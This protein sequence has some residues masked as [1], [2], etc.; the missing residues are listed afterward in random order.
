MKRLI[1]PILI[2]FVMSA[3]CS[4]TSG[5]SAGGQVKDL[6]P[7]PQAGLNNLDSY[8]NLLTLSFSG[9]ANGQAT[10]SVETYAQ[11]VWPALDAMFATINA[12]DETG[13]PQFIV[14]GNV[15]DA[16]YD[17]V[18]HEDPCG[19]WWGETAKAS[20]GSEFNVAALL[21]PVG[22]AK[23][24]GDETVEGV[25]AKHYTF[26]GASVGL[27]EDVQASGDIWLATDGGYVVKYL[28]QITGADSYF[29]AEKQGTQK[30]EYLLSEVNTNP[31]VVYP[32]GCEPVLTE[33]PAT[34]DAA[35][36]IRL[37]GLLDYYSNS[38]LEA[39]TA[40]Y[41]DYFESPGWVKAGDFQPQDGQAVMIFVKQESGDVA[42]LSVRPENGSMSVTVTVL[43]KEG[44]AATV[45]ESGA[46]PQ[47]GTG[48]NAALRV[49]SGLNILLDMDPTQP[50][51]PSYHM[52][53]NH[54]APAW[55][56]NKMVQYEDRMV[57]D[58]EGKNVHF[59][60][61]V[62]KPGG[63]V[64]SSE[65]YNI[66]EQ[67]YVLKDG[68]ATEG[69]GFTSMAWTLWPL[70]PVTILGT[71][72]TA[73]KLKGT[74][75]IEGRMA[76]V[77][78]IAAT[79]PLS[80]PGGIGLSVTAVNGQVWIDQETGALL[81]AVLDYQAD[82]KDADGNAKGNGPGRLEINVSQVGSTTV[83]LP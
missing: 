35:E 4:L 71:G 68:V 32:E 16:H 43:E 2:F 31:L 62:T 58:V 57:A 55:E 47:P 12:L 25:P 27:P 22:A 82:V 3:A 34:E 67:E 17:Q 37:P 81:K 52:E 41:A 46:T 44:A 51:F 14:A 21:N 39:I 45:P 9:T 64:T 13:Q 6:L 59:N 8:T 65:A 66:D 78:D 74:E 61:Q 1:V 40:F 26:D 54:Q 29:G 79:G 5:I 36:I 19:V 10:E 73:A 38:S 20:G 15:G 75:E 18:G 70:D 53:S 69:L 50:T 28:L 30:F 77:Y 63:S 83:T 23:L 76:E 60:D 24:A 48:V 7:D 72:A 80:A 42:F 56:N 33:V 49:A 11:S